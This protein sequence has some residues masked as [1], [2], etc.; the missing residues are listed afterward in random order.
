V[1]IVAAVI[2]LHL[3]LVLAVD[4]GLLSRQAIVEQGA[5]RRGATLVEPWRLVTSLVLHS[6]VRHVLANGLSMLVFAVP[7]LGWVGLPRAAMVYL[8]A[9]IGGG[10]TAVALADFGV[11]ILGS[12]GAVA[13]L[14][15]AWVVLALERASLAD[16]P[17]RAR[18]RTAGIALLVLPSLVNPLTAEGRPVSVSSHLGGALTGMLVGMALSRGWLH[19]SEVEVEPRPSSSDNGDGDGGAFLN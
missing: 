14:F 11:S 3:L 19:R 15:G 8:A 1:L 4:A 12:S 17:G 5:L 9:G 7:L 6:S 16:L 10:I 18:L 13:G 2:A